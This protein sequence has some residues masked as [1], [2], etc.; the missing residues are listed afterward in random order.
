MDT[1]FEGSLC[2]KQL[3]K[4]EE[5]RYYAASSHYPTLYTAYRHPVLVSQRWPLDFKNVAFF[6]WVTYSNF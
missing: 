6:K 2:L 5:C 3:E 4:V 1:E